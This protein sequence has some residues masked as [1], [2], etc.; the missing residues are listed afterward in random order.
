MRSDG[1]GCDNGLEAWR[2]LHERFEPRTAESETTL[3]THVFAIAQQ[4][5]KETKDVPQ[6]ISDLEARVRKYHEVCI[7]SAIP[8]EQQ[9]GL[10]MTI[11]P[12]A[13]KTHMSQHAQ[14]SWA[15]YKAKV[16]EFVYLRLA[17]LHR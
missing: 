14:L 9:K 12:A 11:L 16:F 7:T 1:E 5:I 4:S 13:M 6:A 10:I 3:L 2:A 15:E 8:A 17:D